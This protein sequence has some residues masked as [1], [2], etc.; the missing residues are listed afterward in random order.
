MPAT[1]FADRSD[2]I[3][4]VPIYKPELAPMEA[5]SLAYSLERI[6]GRTVRFMAPATL[7][8]SDYEARHPGIPVDRFDDAC[9]ASIPGYNRLLMSEGFYAR[10]SDFEFMLILQTDA[11]LF[12]DELSHWCNKPY[13]YVGAPW[14]EGLNLSINL[15]RFAGDRAVQ[16]QARVGNGGLSLRRNR[17]CIALLREFPQALSY[18]LQSGSSE[19]LFFSI[20]GT[21][22]YE[23]V[24]PH[25]MAASRFALELR[26]E[27]YL[28]L[29]GGQPPMGAHAW[30]R[31]NMPLWNGFLDR[32]PPELHPASGSGKVG[33]TAPVSV[34]R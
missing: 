26:P 10:Y 17:A 30:W 33:F 4:L 6:P 15:D 7:D 8:T 5:F 19:D 27:Y 31:Y 21:L 32:T 14:P 2:V 1:P 11:I 18:F 20:M 28:A 13:D 29:Q 9:F 25:E 3:V 34:L 23:F 22:S 24:L 16:V 12:R